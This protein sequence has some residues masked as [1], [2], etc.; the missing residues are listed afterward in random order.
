MKSPNRFTAF[1][2]LIFFGDSRVLA[3]DTFRFSHVYKVRS[4]KDTFVSYCIET[5]LAPLI[6]QI[7]TS[8][9]MAM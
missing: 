1:C 2:L 5:R 3:A 8:G 9:R 7:S 6:S 4:L